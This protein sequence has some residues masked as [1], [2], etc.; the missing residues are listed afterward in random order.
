VASLKDV[1]LVASIAGTNDTVIELSIDAA[2]S[3]TGF[4]YALLEFTHSK[5]QEEKIEIKIEKW[6]IVSGSVNDGTFKVK[7]IFV[8]TDSDNTAAIASYAYKSI[9][10][11]YSGNSSG[12]DGIFNGEYILSQVTIFDQALNKSVI[13]PVITPSFVIGNGKYPSFDEK[14]PSFSKDP[15]V[16]SKSILDN[17]TEI[18]IEASILDEIN[19]FDGAQLYFQHEKD[20]DKQFT[21]AIDAS[22]LVS[23]NSISGEYKTLAAIVNS[24]TEYN[25]AVAGY[26]YKTVINS[27]S[28]NGEVLWNG[29]YSLTKAKLL[30]KGGNSTELSLDNI[31][32]VIISNSA[33]GDF[34]APLVTSG[35][36]L[37]TQTEAQ[38]TA[39]YASITAS[40][41]GS[42]VKEIVLHFENTIDSDAKFSFKL[43]NSD[44]ESG[45]VN[46]GTYAKKLALV[47]SEDEYNDSISSYSYDEVIKTFKAEGSSG[48]TEGVYKLTKTVVSDNNGNISTLTP[49]EAQTFE[50]TSGIALKSDF[51]AATLSGIGFAVASSSSK[52]GEATID[53]KST[54]WKQLKIGSASFSTLN[55]LDWSL[56]KVGELQT[57]ELKKVDWS[58][59]NTSS[60]SSE[61]YSELDWS[62]V[63]I[64][65]FTA[66]SKNSLDWSKVKIGDVQTE[67]VKKLDW[68]LVKVGDLQTE[69]LKKVDWSA[70]NTST[71]SSET[72]S[73]LDWSTVKI[74]DVTSESKK[75]LD[76]SKIKIG[77]DNGVA[78][79]SLSTTD[80]M[81]VTLGSQAT[82][83]NFK[84]TDWNKVSFGEFSSESYK[85]IE[86][87][88]MKMNKLTSS[89]YSTIDWTEV[90]FGEFQKKQYK[91]TNWNQVDFG[92]F[93][94][95][96][97]SMIN[98]GQVAF[99][100]AKSVNYSSL[101]W[102]QVDFG[103]FKTSSFKKV[104]WSKVQT[105]DLT[106]EQYSDINWS[107]V[108]FKG[109]T[110]PTLSDLDLSLVIGS[111]SFS[112]KNA[113]QIDWSTISTDDLSSSALSKLS[114]LG[115][116]K[117]G[118]NVAELLKPGTQSKELSFAGVGQAQGGA[119]TT[120]QD[121][122]VSG[123]EVLLAAVEKEPLLI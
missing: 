83:V 62:T 44:L 98:W 17:D 50:I 5:S 48:L 103:D 106:S 27:T 69:E 2:D 76:W 66:E 8:D 13:E 33:D 20:L 21:I 100:G 84:K 91:Q 79:E 102:S 9:F 25:N 112:K 68:S 4:Q 114:G 96:D 31:G 60:F 93:T 123:A 85:G 87:S 117:K 46:S 3:G 30:D 32:S 61:T 35:I 42:G 107:K 99:K 111:S 41:S 58:S 88:Q 16:G 95:E 86:W 26:N 38:K 67:E 34:E 51:E 72:Y 118:T 28:Y 10:Q 90:Q 104:D 115:V 119:L 39:V 64:G 7:A 81:Q 23:G 121:S 70:V 94:A 57:E 108:K 29:K 59:V 101:D 113:K 11:T 37:E 14:G 36:A 110:A 6:D 55:S 43:D 65:D 24:G 78:E 40:D 105:A 52:A 56:V 22:Q 89:T 54:D 1:A 92:D 73:E 15:S 97:Y 80:L 74:G 109:S 19:G 71:F 77:G 18:T 75:T 53:Y 122:S 47:A 116:K 45:T 12:T 63:K 82:T 49:S 120:G